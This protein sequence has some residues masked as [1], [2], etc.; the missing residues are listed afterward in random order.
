[1]KAIQ[2]SSL[3]QGFSL[4]ELMVTV[5]LIGIVAAIGLPMYTDYVDTAARGVMRQNIDSIA[6][7]EREY[8]MVNGRYIPATYTPGSAANTTCTTPG[9]LPCGMSSTSSL[10]WAPN[11]ETDVI[12]YV[13]DN[14]S[15]RGF[16]VTATD[17]Q[18]AD[19]VEVKNCTDTSCS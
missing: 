10:N 18:N 3:Q 11:S 19:R 16:R 2:H 9:S 15:F 14:I 6:L 1:M 5:A 7:F 8:K 12:S 17:T 13:I 4:I